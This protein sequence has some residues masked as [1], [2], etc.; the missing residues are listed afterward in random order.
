LIVAATVVGVI[1][2][3]TGAHDDHA[4][5]EQTPYDH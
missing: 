4:R 3:A 1:N 2:A 5:E